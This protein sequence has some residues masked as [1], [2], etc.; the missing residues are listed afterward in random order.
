MTALALRLDRVVLNTRVV[1]EQ[2]LLRL[3][4]LGDSF[5][6]SRLFMTRQVQAANRLMAARE[7]FHG[8]LGSYR[9][10]NLAHETLHRCQIPMTPVVEAAVDLLVDA[11]E[12]IKVEKTAGFDRIIELAVARDW[13]VFGFAY[14]ERAAYWRALAQ[15]GIHDYL[16]DVYLGD[17]PEAAGWGE[18]WEA[19]GCVATADTPAADQLLVVT[20]DPVFD[21]MNAFAIGASCLLFERDGHGIELPAVPGVATLEQFLSAHWPPQPA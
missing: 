10:K 20:P 7:P 6:R 14:G 11:V 18:F 9:W 3:V 12:S 1:E 13:R 21:P 17:E 4:G 8:G 2:F 5:G 19:H 15:A 16:T